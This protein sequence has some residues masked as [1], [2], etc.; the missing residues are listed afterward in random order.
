MIINKE[1]N[2]SFCRFMLKFEIKQRCVY[3]NKIGAF[4]KCLSGRCGLEIFTRA[5]V[6]WNK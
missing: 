6:T 4:G 3:T 5:M 1:Q 2:D